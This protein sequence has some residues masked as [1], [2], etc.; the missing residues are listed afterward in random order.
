[1]VTYGNS[2]WNTATDN[3]YKSIISVQEDAYEKLKD[4]INNS[5]IN[6]YAYVQNGAVRMAVDDK[7]INRLTQI[8]GTEKV[9]VQKSSKP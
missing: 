3:R 5:G 6:Y 7:D 2:F 8:T 1:M 4:A 9:N